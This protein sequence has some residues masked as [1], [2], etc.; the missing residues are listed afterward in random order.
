[1]NDIKVGFIEINEDE[2]VNKLLEYILINIS[3][4]P[5][6]I[7]RHWIHHKYP[8]S[9]VCNCGTIEQ[10]NFTPSETVSEKVNDKLRELGYKVEIIKMKQSGKVFPGW[11]VTKPQG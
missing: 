1:M 7:N 6:P 4:A 2:H 11:Y 8:V 9:F 3:Q 5:N 10:R